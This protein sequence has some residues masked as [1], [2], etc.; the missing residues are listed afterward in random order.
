MA[1]PLGDRFVLIQ[2]MA[3]PWRGDR[4]EAAWTPV[5]EAALDYGARGWAFFRDEEERAK[6]TQLAFFDNKLDWERYW[7]SDQLAQARAEATGLFQ[8][9][10]Q[11]VWQKLIG[12]G[13]LTLV[14]AGG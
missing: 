6:F 11:P 4:F 14:P 7:Y 2:W 5:A 13:A 1:G 12:F 3:N 10:V 8:V 9:P